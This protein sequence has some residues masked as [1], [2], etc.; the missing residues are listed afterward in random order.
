MHV[1]V[2]EPAEVEHVSLEQVIEHA[3][4]HGCAVTFAPGLSTQHLVSRHF[5]DRTINARLKRFISSGC[6]ILGDR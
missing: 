6:V 2:L 4:A 1:K 5:S 3:H